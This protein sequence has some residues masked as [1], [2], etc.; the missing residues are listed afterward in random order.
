VARTRSADGTLIAYDVYG[1][2]PRLVLVDGAL[3]SRR[4]GPSKGLVRA[5][6][7]RFTVLSYDRRGRGESGDGGDYAVERELEDLLAVIAAGGGPTFL[8]G[9]SS[10]AILA[11]HAAARS[12]DVS[13]LVVYEAPFIV[14]GTRPPTPEDYYE[15]LERLLAEKR[16]GAAVRLFLRLVGMPGP[17]IVA[18]GLTPMWPRLKAVAPTLSYDSLITAPYQRGA[19]LAPEAWSTATQPA[20]V[21][22][23]GKSGAWMRNGMQALARTLPH[24]TYAVLDGQTHNL[25]PRVVTPELLRFFAPPATTAGSERTSGAS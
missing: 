20:L 22:A 6:A 9:Q 14:D 21:L 16:R 7:G 13:R 19:P 12:G 8:F 17:A 24:A 10:G 11:L 1:A 25:K 5:L 2:G 4:M 3:C 15:T 23:G 18:L